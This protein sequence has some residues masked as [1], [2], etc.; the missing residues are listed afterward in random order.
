MR[1]LSQPRAHSCSEDSRG[2]Q[3]HAS[4]LPEWYA[5]YT[6][7]RQERAVKTQLDERAVEN[8]LQTYEKISQWKDRKKLIQVPLFPGYLFV[9]VLFARRL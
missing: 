4:L 2:D 8:F 9:K 6:R 1:I 3:D 7:S 5:V